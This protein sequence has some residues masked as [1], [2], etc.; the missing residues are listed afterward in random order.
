M[1]RRNNS[2][3]S[4]EKEHIMGRT[5]KQLTLDILPSEIIQSKKIVEKKKQI[6][7][8]SIGL[9]LDLKKDELT[10]QV[11]FRLLPSKVSFSK[12]KADLWFNNNK[13]KSVCFDILHAF[14]NT[15]DFSLR[16][17]LD[18]NGVSPGSHIVKVEVC[19]VSSFRKK[20][21]YTLNETTVEYNPPTREERLRKVLTIKKVEGQGISVISE[22]EKDLYREIEDSI[23]K[24]VESKQDK[25]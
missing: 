14:G 22:K 3:T 6:V 25:W 10:L 16:A 5:G 9:D 23:K 11:D 24:K 4:K 8:N 19:E 2:V 13:V 20:L 18:S 15:D 7:I 1:G 17:T 12:L 21:V